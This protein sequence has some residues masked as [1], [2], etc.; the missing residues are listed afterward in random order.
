[1]D[2]KVAIFSTF[3]LFALFFLPVQADVIEPG[4]HYVQRCVAFDNARSFPGVT[5]LAW[6][7]EVMGGGSERYYVVED[8][9]CLEKG[10]KFNT[11]SIEWYAGNPLIRGM[12]VTRS[13]NSVVTD[14]SDVFEV[15]GGYVDDSSPL[16]AENLTY[17]FVEKTS[18]Y[19]VE[20]VSW[21]KKN[22]GSDA[23]V[24]L[25]SGAPTLS[26]TATPVAVTLAPDA[27]EPTPAPTA[28]VTPT[29]T[30]AVSVSPSPSL[31]AAPGD[32]LSGVLCFFKRLFGGSC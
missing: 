16:E 26:P 20:L 30:P 22:Q 13:G 11:L 27:P 17:R 24:E 8:G 3:A 6:V 29:A 10:Y 21:L 1:M 9:V 14:G 2:F 5:F 19:G 32:W 23:W 31:T 28:T 18:G 25:G 12:P 7:E 15:Y 4:T